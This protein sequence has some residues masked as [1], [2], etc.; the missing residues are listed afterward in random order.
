MAWTNLATSLAKPIASLLTGSGAALQGIISSPSPLGFAALDDQI[1]PQT[2]A[3]V[4]VAPTPMLDCRIRAHPDNGSGR[5]RIC[6]SAVSLTHGEILLA[7]E[8]ASFSVDDL[9]TLSWIADKPSLKAIVT[10]H[11]NP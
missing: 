8:Q 9:H 3:P 2:A 5:I 10:Y 1:V 11:P 6:N 7:G 4:V